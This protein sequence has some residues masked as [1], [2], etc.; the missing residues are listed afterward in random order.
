[1]NVR[2][3]RPSDSSFSKG[4]VVSE[5]MYAE[6]VYLVWSDGGEIPLGIATANEMD[7]VSVETARWLEGGHERGILQNR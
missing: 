4:L 1:M 3:V 2:I 7:I 6:M 5:G